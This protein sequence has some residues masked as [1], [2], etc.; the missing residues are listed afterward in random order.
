MVDVA[1]GTTLQIATSGA[2]DLGAVALT[3]SGG[4]LLLPDGSVAMPRV[5]VY[6]VTAVPSE[7]GSFLADTVSMLSPRQIAR[8]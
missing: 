1:A 4:Q 8:Y 7:T 5:H 6:D 2:F 3:G